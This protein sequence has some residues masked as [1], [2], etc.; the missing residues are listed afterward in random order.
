MNTFFKN[1][2]EF[3]YIANEISIVAFASSYLKKG[4]CK[5]KKIKKITPLHLKQSTYYSTMK[6]N[7]IGASFAHSKLL[8]NRDYYHKNENLLFEYGCRRHCSNSPNL[9]P[10]KSALYKW[11]I[12]SVKIINSPH[13]TVIQKIT[14]IG[15]SGIL[16]I[17]ATLGF[18]YLYCEF[19]DDSALCQSI[20]RQFGLIRK[21]NTLPTEASHVISRKK[22]M[23][24]IDSFFFGSN[25]PKRVA[26]VIGNSADG[27]TELAK[28][29][30]RQHSDYHHLWFVQ[31]QN[32]EKEYRNLARE[33][34]LIPENQI[35]SF[36]IDV[37]IRKVHDAISKRG[38][39]GKRSLIVFDDAGSKFFGGN[40]KGQLPANADILVTS[41]DCGWESV[42]ESI[43]DLRL[44]EYR[45]THDEGME[46]LRKW[47][48][49]E[50]FIA[51][52]AGKIVE[53][54]NRL[55]VPIAQA[56]NF[57]KR[58]NFSMRDYLELFEKNKRD[59][60][61]QG[62][63][64][65]RV[66]EK[67]IDIFVS[68][69]MTIAQIKENHV[70]SENALKLLRYCICLPGKDIPTALLEKLLGC[71]KL[72]LNRYL[73]MLDTLVIQGKDRVS[74]HDLFQDLLAEESP[75]AEKELSQIAVV[76]SQFNSFL[77][78]HPAKAI[79][80]YRQGLLEAENNHEEQ[81]IIDYAINLGDA[82]SSLENYNDAVKYYKIVL[83]I[84][85][86]TIGETHEDTAESYLWM[87]NSLFYLGHYDEAFIYSQK[88]LEIFNEISKKKDLRIIP[89]YNS[90]AIVLEKLSRYKEALEYY[91][92]SLN[93]SI[94]LLNE[95]DSDLALT[96]NNIGSVLRALNRN[97]EALKYR[98]KALNIFIKTLG[99]DHPHTALGYN[100][101]GSLFKDL[102]FINDALE[103]YEKALEIRKKINEN[104]TDTA[105]IYNNM[106][107]I[108]W[109]LKRYE[110]A[111]QNQ[112]KA[113]DILIKVIG[114][115]HPETA[116]AYCNMGSYNLFLGYH[117]KAL[118]YLQKS[119][120]IRIKMLGEN[121]EATAVSYNNISQVFL[122]LKRY[123]EALNCQKKALEIFINVL[124]DDHPR[125]ISAYNNLKLC[126]M[127]FKLK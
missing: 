103:H 16:G 57:I 34:N 8:G 7:S 48:P 30:A 69:K 24:K 67:S 109:Y 4:A 28:Q 26:V 78:T 123:D 36:D 14:F 73:G 96:Y 42:V 101:V 41:R 33:W 38:V 104:H 54:F 107:S 22:P 60:I 75:P 88:A 18:G 55:P 119:L 10:K 85:R 86:K 110:D 81:R 49:H 5:Q 121:N 84:R 37:V 39:L 77:M 12:N 124:G 2:T 70:D 27:K 61:S 89:Y 92:K 59:V 19:F 120:D 25:Q 100:N 51:G 20:Y 94:E 111:L 65:S 105:K 91:Q 106:A 98:Q 58:K 32:W 122:A 114:E 11:I 43:I 113:L 64:P 71:T 50:K 93:I 116:R 62:H 68:L 47:I 53:R 95:N 87:A 126:E 56:G 66:D 63:L 127:H 74:I 17:I 79:F 52:E 99:E 9:P 82:F 76:S 117:E 115:N 46:I 118:P 80:I 90:N 3:N 29:Y 97:S 125:T 1:W 108:F 6:I 35:K 112:Q 44:E 23:E 31:A 72:E 83:D 102:G 15:G 45:L 13:T 21:I 40:L